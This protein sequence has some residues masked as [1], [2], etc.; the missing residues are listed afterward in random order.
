[1]DNYLL[2]KSLHVLGVVIFLGNIIVTAGGGL[3]LTAPSFQQAAGAWH[4]VASKAIRGSVDFH[5][6]L[7]KKLRCQPHDPHSPSMGTN[8][9]PSRDGRLWLSR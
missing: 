2:L 4:D 5:G 3:S 1:M 6:N 7:V 8:K 9:N